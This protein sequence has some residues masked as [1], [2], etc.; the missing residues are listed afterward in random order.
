M[1]W[2]P[3]V[4]DLVEGV[5]QGALL[6]GLECNVEV[7][8]GAGGRLAQ[9]LPVGWNGTPGVFHLYVIPRYEGRREVCDG[10]GGK[11]AERIEPVVSHE[12][13]RSVTKVISAIPLDC[14]GQKARGPVSPTKHRNGEYLA[15]VQSFYSAFQRKKRGWSGTAGPTM[16][17]TECNPRLST[18]PG[19]KRTAET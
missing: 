15:E 8:G 19:H 11:G 6:V 4:A 9:T 12:H 16:E 5:N 13:R 14:A 2:M 17:S 10:Q 1:P 3:V 18:E 7:D